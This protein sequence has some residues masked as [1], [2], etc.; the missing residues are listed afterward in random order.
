[1]HSAHQRRGAALERLA[2]RLPNAVHRH[3]ERQQQRLAQAAQAL[4]LLDP[5]HVLQRG[6]AWLADADGQP[7][8]RSTQ[9]QPGQPITARLADGALA[10]TV[11]Q[12]LTT[13]P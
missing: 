4:G 6:Y 8:T 7:I 12:R 2:E 3:T 1:M 13:T 10:L 9:A 11:Q 5:R